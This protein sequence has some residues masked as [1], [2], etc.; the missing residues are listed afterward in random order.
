VV[1][2]E[3]RLSHS[4]EKELGDLLKRI[5]PVLWERIKALAREPK[6]KRSKKLE[7]AEKAYRLPIR[8]YRI[9]HTV[10]DK[11]KLVTVTAIR[12][13]KEAYPG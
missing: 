1:S 6:P 2:Y 12:H 7:G 13:R 8:N 10:E 11:Q 3:V 4:A 9:V 5:V